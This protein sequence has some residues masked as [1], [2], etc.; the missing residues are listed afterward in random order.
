MSLPFEDLTPH[1]NK[2]RATSNGNASSWGFKDEMKPWANKLVYSIDL[3][4][5]QVRYFIEDVSVSD[6]LFDCNHLVFHFS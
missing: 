6:I 2:E 5:D 1:Y 3:W 4:Q